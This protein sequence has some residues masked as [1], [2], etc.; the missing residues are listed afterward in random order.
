MNAIFAARFAGVP[1]S[2]AEARRFVARSL[3]G[4]HAELC[5]AATV[6][7]SELASNAVLHTS[8]DFTVSVDE[9]PGGVRI[10]VTDDGGGRPRLRRPKVTELHGRGLQI[11]G[12]L[13]D[14]WGVS[15]SAAG[16]GKSVWFELRS[17]PF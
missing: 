14:A 16:P 6:V 2:V 10:T 5:D 11:V 3:G 13:A 15:R 17:A 8:T 7:V 12:E 9:V 1:A 4:A